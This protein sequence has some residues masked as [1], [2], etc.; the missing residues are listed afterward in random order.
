MCLPAYL[1]ETFVEKKL[2]PFQMLSSFIS[3]IFHEPFF[4]SKNM[5][6]TAGISG[7]K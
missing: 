4:K 2:P 3:Q 6:G 5:E 7:N 1:F